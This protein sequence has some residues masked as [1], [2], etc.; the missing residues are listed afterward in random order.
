M[1][2]QA[3]CALYVASDRVQVLRYVRSESGGW[4]VSGDNWSIQI[5]VLPAALNEKIEEALNVSQ[6]KINR[7]LSAREQER[8]IIYRILKVK[9]N[10]ELTLEYSMYWIRKDRHQIQIVPSVAD[11]IGRA[12]HYRLLEEKALSFGNPEASS[13]FESLTVMIN[14][15]HDTS[16][17]FSE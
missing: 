1:T 16:G 8:P 7:Y 5:P 11:G 3:C 6:I 13:F 2:A 17:L 9:N 14:A 12:R 4:R 10:L 15:N